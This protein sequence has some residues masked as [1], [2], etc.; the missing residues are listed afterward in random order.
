MKTIFYNTKDIHW[1]LPSRERLFK[2]LGEYDTMAEFVTLSERFFEKACKDAESY[3]DFVNCKAIEFDVKIRGGV[4]LENYRESLYKSFMVNSYAMFNDFVY[5]FRDDMK[6][7][8]NNDF[9]I[10]DNQQMSAYER[11]LEA[12]KKA[13]FAPIIPKWLN[14]VVSYYRLIRNHVAHND[15]DD[16]KCKEAYSKIDVAQM[17]HEYPVF[18]NKAPNSPERITMNDFYLYSA[19]IKHI[20][21]LLTI[22]IQ[23]HENWSNLGL[24]HPSLQRS[25]IP[26]GTDKRKLVNQVLNKLGVRCTKDTVDCILKNVRLQYN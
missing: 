26:S 11:L 8:V 18:E 13:G 20:A 12:M 21:N 10:V 25:R 17:V 9:V 3:S 16:K 1:R 15:N 4:T 22:S 24:Y 7:F 23:G 6:L 5:N 2:R 19:S 14:D